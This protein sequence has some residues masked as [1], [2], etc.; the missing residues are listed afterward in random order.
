MVCLARYDPSTGAWREWPL[1]GNDPAA[2]AVYVD[3]ND[4]VWLSDFG[5]NAVLRFDPH[6]KM[7][8]SFPNPRPYA[9]VRQMLGRA[10][11]VWGPSPGPIT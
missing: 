10:G 11:E 3:E 9:D 5:A 8:Q 2:Y 1:P 6:S 4:R 7:F